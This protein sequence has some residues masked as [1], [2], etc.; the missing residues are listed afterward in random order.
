MAENS[1]LSM[2]FTLVSDAQEWAST[3]VEERRI[4]IEEDAR[5]KKEED[6][7]RERVR[8]SLKTNKGV[9]CLAWPRGEGFVWCEF[10]PSPTRSC[11]TEAKAYELK[12][13]Q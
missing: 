1:G 9:Y 2:V 5:R 6:E 10:N 3:C 12:Q 4:R 8:C 11:I 13:F 7:E